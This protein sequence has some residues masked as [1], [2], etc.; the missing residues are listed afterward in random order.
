MGGTGGDLPL[1]AVA[2]TLFLCAKSLNWKRYPVRLTAESWTQVR[3]GDHRG[4][5]G[6]LL[7]AEM[8][9]VHGHHPTS[10]MYL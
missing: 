1:M 4:A 3:A 10:D 9:A 5:M 7:A 2:A 8:H 6:G